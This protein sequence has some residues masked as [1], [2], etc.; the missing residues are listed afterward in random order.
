MMW[1]DLIAILT[2]VCVFVALYQAVI[3]T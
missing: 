3:D 2:L 1:V